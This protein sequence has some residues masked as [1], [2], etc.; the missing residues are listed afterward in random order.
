MQDVREQDCAR[1]KTTEKIEMIEWLLCIVTVVS[2]VGLALNLILIIILRRWIMNLFAKVDEA[3]T[4]LEDLRVAFEQFLDGVIA[5]GSEE[6][7]WQDEDFE[8]EE[9]EEPV[10]AKKKK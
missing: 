1:G 8:I 7:P 6:E 4:V 9:D 2:I 10:K 3:V 5:L